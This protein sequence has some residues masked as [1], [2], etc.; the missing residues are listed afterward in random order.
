MIRPIIDQVPIVCLEEENEEVP[1]QEPQVPP[2]P[3]E[4]LVPQMLPILQAHF[5]EG[6]MTNAELRFALMNLTQ[7]LTAQDHVIN[8]HFVA[9]SN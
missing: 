5:V 1:L 7:L 8:N 3:K 6:H 2:E 4:P 9:Q